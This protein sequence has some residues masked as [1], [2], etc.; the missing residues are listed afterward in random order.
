LGIPPAVWGGGV[1]TVFPFCLRARD[2]RH[3]AKRA[4]FGGTPNGNRGRFGLR[5]SA[6]RSQLRPRSC[7]GVKDE[8][9]CAGGGHWIFDGAKLQKN[10]EIALNLCKTVK[11]VIL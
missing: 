3:S 1:T 7:R 11:I 8:T 4:A 10:R 6:R 9:I 5:V 2:H